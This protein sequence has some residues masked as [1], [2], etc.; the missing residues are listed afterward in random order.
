MMDDVTPGLREIQSGPVARLL[1][2][3][4][5]G[6]AE[7]EGIL[8]RVRWLSPVSFEALCASLCSDLGYALDTGNRRRMISLLLGLL[9][10]CGQVKAAGGAWQW[11]GEDATST[12]GRG[13][14]GC[15]Q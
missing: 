12:A 1:L 3:D 13:S 8:A 6:L 15:I 4:I 7:R 5:L 9:A 14:G 11:C 2:A 10:E